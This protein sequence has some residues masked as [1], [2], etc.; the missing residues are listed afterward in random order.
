MPEAIPLETAGLCQDCAH[1][2]AN[3]KR[4]DKCQS[5]AMLPLAEVLNRDKNE[6]AAQRAPVERLN[7]KLDE[8]LTDPEW[9]QVKQDFAA[10]GLRAERFN[11]ATE[12][13]E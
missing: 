5:Q 12:E 9:K 13:W 7:A 11:A 3:R 4:C 1:I 2:S 10:I 8:V 6:P